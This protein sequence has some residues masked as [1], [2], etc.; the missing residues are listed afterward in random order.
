MLKS[1]IIIECGGENDMFRS[2]CELYSLLPAVIEINIINGTV[3]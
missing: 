3:H 2:R 1:I